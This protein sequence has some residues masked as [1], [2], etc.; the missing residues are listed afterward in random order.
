[1]DSSVLTA[2]GYDAATRIL[3]L[4]FTS[5]AVYEYAEVPAEEHAALLA[6]PSAGR[7]FGARIRDRYPTRR[8]QGLAPGPA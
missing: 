6:A 1:M 7:F 3:V 8:L 5:G 4:A 2:V